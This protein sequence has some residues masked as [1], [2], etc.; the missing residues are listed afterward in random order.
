MRSLRAEVPVWLGFAGGVIVLLAAFFQPPVVQE[1]AKV[2][3]EWNIILAAFALALGSGNLFR[4]HINNIRLKRGAWKFSFVTIITLAGYIALGVA[5]GPKAA[6]YNWVFDTAYVPIQATL[7]AL[8]AF[9]I[10]TAC[11]RA[12][13]IRNSQA[14][15][16]LA[17]GVIV[18]LGKVGIG[19]VMWS[20]F[21]PAA[22]WIMNYPNS[23]GMRSL[24]MA[25]ALGMLGVGIRVILGMERGHLGGE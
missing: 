9:W 4:V 13:R 8:N 16:L 1:P 2:F 23:A 3:L 14:I 15:V 12:F 11:Y 24:G 7:F 6:S 25:A 20:G 10:A 18:M 19:N 17:S 21:A 5:V 22:D